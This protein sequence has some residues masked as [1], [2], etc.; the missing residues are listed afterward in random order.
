M[1]KSVSLAL[2]NLNRHYASSVVGTVQEAIARLASLIQID[3]KKKEKHAVAIRCLQRLA[4]NDEYTDSVSGVTI[5][6]LLALVDRMLL[7]DAMLLC[8]QST[9]VSHLIEALYEIQRGYN[10]S[11][12]GIDDEQLED[13]PICPAGAMNKLIERFSGVHPYCEIRFV[14]PQT[15][16]R[17]LQSLVREVVVN[18]FVDAL[19]A[20][21]QELSLNHFC[22]FML[23]CFQSDVSVLW[24]RI[25]G[26]VNHF[27]QLE[28]YNY[29]KLSEEFINTG[30][31]VCLD[32]NVDW[33]KILPY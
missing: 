24:S 6:R 14:T 5:K 7:D 8:D 25:Y 3:K 22:G 1:H 4:R 13:L 20:G 27:M 9:A 16:S 11:E 28:F 31:Y 30:K 2:K 15:A 10:L 21:S 26:T 33:P 29:L 23:S 19:D 12:E 32:G 17:K 18:H